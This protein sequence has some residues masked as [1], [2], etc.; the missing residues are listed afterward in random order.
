MVKVIHVYLVFEKRNYYFSSIKKV[1]D[2]LDS[3]TLGIKKGYLY[4]ALN[5]DGAVKVTPRAIIARSHLK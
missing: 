4:K 1:Y 3:N 5:E 2:D